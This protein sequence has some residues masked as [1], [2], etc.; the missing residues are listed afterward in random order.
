MLY[1]IVTTSIFNDCEI[2]K[3]QYINC[4]NKL[5]DV[6]SVNNIECKIIIVENNGIR[7]TY[8][9]E[10][11]CDVLYTNNN[12]IS[13]NNKGTK[14]LLDIYSCIYKFDIKDEDFIVKI[15]GRYLLHDNSEFI[16]KLKNNK[17]DCIIKYGSYYKPVDYKTNDCITGLIGMKCFYLKQINIPNEFECVEWNWAK[18]TNIINDDKIYKI[19][20]LGIDICP[21]SN[22]YFSV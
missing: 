22:Q 8:L 6:I 16:S 10:L 17:Y 15:T 14:E 2:R 11:N 1:I 4:I 21:G 12:F 13:S 3:K 18:I 19:N 20:K 9:D 7:K 5:K